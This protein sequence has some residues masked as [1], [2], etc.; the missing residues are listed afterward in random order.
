[1]AHEAGAKVLIDGAQ[2]VA[3]FPTDV[4]DIDC[5][6]YAFSGHKLYGPTGIGVLYGKRDLLEAMPPFHG[7]GD[8]IET[9]TWEKTTYA[10]LPNKF[11][12]G[13]P[14]I[15]GVVGLG[16]A[17]DYLTSIGFEVLVPYEHELLEYA[18]REI[19]KLPGLRIIGTAKSKGSVLSFVMED[20]PVA[21]LDLGMMLDAEGIAVRTGHHCGMPLMK[22]LGISATTRASFA[23]YNT[24]EEVDAL[25][26]A[27]RKI[28][29]K[30]TS[31]ER[32]SAAARPASAGPE[33]VFPEASGPS[34]QAVA[35]EL[36]DV[37]A[38][39]D[40]RN[41]K[42]EQ[43]LDYGRGLPKYFDVLKTLTQRIPGCMSQVYVIAR[44]VPGSDD[45]RRFEFIADADADIVRGEIAILQKLYSGQRARDVL[46]FDIEGFFNRIGLEH[47][48]TAQ[49][50]TGL[51]SMV[52]RIRADAA[53]IA[54]S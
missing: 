27:L 25:V 2:W 48:L 31:R 39:L 7:G 24:R 8:M 29:S 38:F 11:E 23:M 35:D 34:P 37:F 45:E 1:M 52:K 17:I 47:F 4:Q 49:R 19:G 50:R 53:A 51:A 18:T 36:A 10:P 33:L 30:Q 12:A 22:R 13:T 28:I 54:Q 20:P 3:H 42:N 40:D 6:F 46:D 32:K 21:P 44:R 9:V 26:S 16:A 43:V 41:A 5:D 14:D 15:A